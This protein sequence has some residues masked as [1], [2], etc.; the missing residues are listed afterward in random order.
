MNLNKY[1]G[2]I[3]LA[4]GLII[5]AGTLWQSYN[6]FTGKASV[7]LVFMTPT[8]L[9]SQGGS[10]VNEQINEAVKKQIEQIIP[11]SAITKIFNLSVWSFLA[12]IFMMGGSIVSSIGVKLLKV[13]G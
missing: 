2:Y 6:V 9:K 12:V 3:L 13:S 5:I 11:S 7:P 10:Q 8:A 4:I 1:I